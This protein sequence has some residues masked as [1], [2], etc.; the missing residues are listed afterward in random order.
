MNLTFFHLFSSWTEKKRKKSA[1][2]LE[3][4]W[5]IME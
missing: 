4:D 1:F 2:F 5:K 3:T